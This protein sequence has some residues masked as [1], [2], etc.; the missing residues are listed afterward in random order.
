MNV[1]L[2]LR[3]S[4]YIPYYSPKYEELHFLVIYLLTYKYGNIHHL[5]LFK[6]MQNNPLRRHVLKII[7]LTGRM[8]VLHS[9]TNSFKHTFIYWFTSFF[10]FQCFFRMH[11]FIWVPYNLDPSIHLSI[12]DQLLSLP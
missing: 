12:L 11:E 2:Y 7:M 6:F 5:L 9:L 8:L 10:F 4:S 3:L 1:S